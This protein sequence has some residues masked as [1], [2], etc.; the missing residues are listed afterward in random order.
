MTAKAQRDS[1]IMTIATIIAVA[2]L[3]ATLIASI[4]SANMIPLESWG[5]R[6]W[7]FILGTVI[8]LGIT[9]ILGIFFFKRGTYWRSG[10]GSRRS[11]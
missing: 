11:P 1:R 9:G 3:P 6:W 8:L 5:A 4:F 10:V 2:Y 7:H